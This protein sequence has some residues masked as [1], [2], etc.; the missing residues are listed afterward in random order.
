MQPAAPPRYVVVQT[1]ARR[2]YA[3]P[4][5]LERAGTLERFYTD[6]CA[7]VGLG[8]WLAAGR[9]LPWVGA[10]LARLGNR[11][12]PPEIVAKT[13]AIAPP[14]AGVFSGSGGD[15]TRAFRRAARRHLGWTQK[16]VRAGFGEATHLYSMLSEAGAMIGAAKEH[17]LRVVSEV[18]ILLSTERL[19]ERERREFPGWEPDPPDFSTVYAETGGDH[20]MLALSDLFVCPSPVVRDDL[21]TRHGVD[22]ARTAVVPYGTDPRWLELAPAPQRGRVLFAGTADLRKGIHSLALAAERLHARGLR[23]EFRVA[24][25]VT[26][27]VRAQPACRHLTFLGRVPRDRI[28]EEFRAADV[29]A[30]PSLAEGSA[31]VTYEALASALPVVTTAEAGS[32]AREGIE[33][34]IVPARDPTALADAL[35]E[36]VEDRAERDRMAAAARER[37]REF[38]WEQYGYRLLSTLRD[39]E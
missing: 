27:A 11:R 26:P 21:V 15:P 7:D 14:L 12:L 6:Y 20:G 5:I 3:V 33:G 24:G 13:R 10:R 18:Y 19:M 38:T 4:A 31:E 39:R 9:R 25:H 36:V 16:L 28:A 29:F 35:A 34:K 8:R 17:G 30:L 1:G 32:V 2:G 22:A 23:Y 37:A